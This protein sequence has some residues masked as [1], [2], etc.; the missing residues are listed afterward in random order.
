MTARA[1]RLQLWLALIPAA[2]W[3]TLFFL[4]PLLIIGVISMLRAGAPVEWVVDGGS[5][6]RLLNPLHLTI[7]LRSIG[8]AGVATII[9]LL[10]GYPLA[11][12]I[13]RRPPRLRRLL[14]FMVLVP[15]WANSLVLIYA[16]M[17]LLRP[18][19]VFEQ[20]LL[21]LGV[22]GS[23]PLSILYTPAAV[24]IGLVYWYLPF[25]VYPLYAS[26]EK[27][28][29][30]LLDAAYDLGA[31]RVRAFRRI[32]WPMTIPGAAT[33]CLLVFIESLG[34]FVVPD[35]LGGAKSMMLGNLIQQRFLSVPQDWP[36]GAAVAVAL[37]LT[38]G[39][40]LMFYFRLERERA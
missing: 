34:A 16:W 38:M 33:G 18:N 5:L 27:F 25:M 28:D 7:L 8:L 29:F 2:A 13:A 19:G 1:N 26:L 21:W 4:L 32:L 20:L 35:L 39:L 11:Y 9:C 24:L 10:L 30:T 15:L 3:L 22:S 40:A 6:K 14:Y 36:L 17:V 23:A 12:Y 31:S 37:L